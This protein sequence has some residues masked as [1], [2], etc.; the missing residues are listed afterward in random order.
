MSW[1]YFLNLSNQRGRHKFRLLVARFRRVMHVIAECFGAKRQSECVQIDHVHAILLAHAVR[2]V[3]VGFDVRSE[4]SDAEVAP[5]R[6]D[7]IVDG[8]GAAPHDAGCAEL[9]PYCKGLLDIG[10]IIVDIDLQPICLSLDV[11]QA[12]IEKQPRASQGRIAGRE[13]VAKIGH[14]VAAVAAI[15]SG[16]ARVCRI[17]IWILASVCKVAVERAEV[18]AVAYGDGVAEDEEARGHRFYSAHGRRFKFLAKP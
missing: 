9:T 11:V 4:A 16:D 5:A 3:I 15:L 8:R 13:E 18:W 10:D 2:G 12:A 7:R 1:I 6:V 14:D 17:G